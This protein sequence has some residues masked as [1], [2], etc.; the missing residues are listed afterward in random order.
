MSIKHRD[1]LLLSLSNKSSGELAMR[2]LG[3][4]QLLLAI[5]TPI[6]AY[7]G[8]PTSPCWSGRNRP[9]PVE[10]PAKAVAQT[11][12]D[13]ASSQPAALFYRPLCSPSSS[14]GG[15]ELVALLQCCTDTNF[16]R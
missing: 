4:I 14:Q 6:P 7:I 11:P 1:A 16:E 8:E 10:N 2:K 9:L 3:I 13:S 15:S 12:L 5:S